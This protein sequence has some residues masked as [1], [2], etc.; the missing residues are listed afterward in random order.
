MRNKWQLKAATGGSSL[1]DIT[2]HFGKS[3]QMIHRTMPSACTFTSASQ[4]DRIDDHGQ[5]WVE[6]VA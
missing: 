2:L 6:T 1:R 4:S 5:W 3:A